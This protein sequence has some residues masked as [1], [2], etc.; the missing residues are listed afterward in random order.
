MQLS[1]NCVPLNIY[2]KEYGETV[3]AIN[4][5]VQN[6]VWQEGVQIIKVKNVKE[7]WVDLEEVNKW[8]RRNKICHAG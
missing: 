7:R 8:V 2:C 5:R 3:D 1:D 6:G 4:K